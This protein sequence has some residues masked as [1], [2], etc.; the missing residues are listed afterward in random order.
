MLLLSMSSVFGTIFVWKLYTDGAEAYK[1]SNSCLNC[2]SSKIYR[3]KHDDKNNIP[4]TDCVRA[5]S[6]NVQETSSVSSLVVG[7][8]IPGRNVNQTTEKCE[9]QLENILVAQKMDRLLF[10]VIGSIVFV[11]NLCIFVVALLK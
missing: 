5:D 8:K 9:G 6:A 2:V 7:D 4:L 10:R 3:V 1:I 11:L